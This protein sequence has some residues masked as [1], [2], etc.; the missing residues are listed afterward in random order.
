MQ[1]T[2]SVRTL[3]PAPIGAVYRAVWRWHFYA[4]LL[5]LPFLVL[6]A[7]TGGLYLFHK[8]ID[9]IVH[10]D[11][12][13]VP[14]A[15]GAGV[16][17]SVLVANAEKAVPGT[18]LTYITPADPGAAAA[19]GI[20]TP[21]GQR[22]L[23]YLDPSNGRV[24]GSIGEKSTVMGIVR[25][26]HSLAFF[27]VW[28][29]YVIEIVGGWTVVLVMTGLY[30]WWPRGG[31][32]GG[33][34]SVRGTPAKRVFW[35][36]LHAVSGL[37]AAF[38]LAFLAITGMPWSSFWGAQ[39]HRLVDEAGIGFPGG[40]WGDQPVST[41]PLGAV[42]PGVGWTMQDS[43]VPLS[44]GHHHGA[45]AVE[46]DAAALPPSIGLDEAVAIFDKAGLAPGYAVALPQ[47]PRGVY[48]GTVYPADLAKERAIHLDRYSG[49]TLIDVSFANYGWAGK[50]IEWGVNV[51]MGQEFGRL[52][53]IVLALACLL[54]IV[55]AAGALV[56]WWKRRPP[57]ALAAPP[58]PAERRP[59]IVVTAILL[60]L[61]L[62]Y[63]LTGLSMLAM[64][65]IDLFGGHML[66]ARAASAA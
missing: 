44:G 11:L 54:V 38:F 23:V 63:P 66:A 28:P 36:D 5:V 34:I 15:T 45:P 51:H 48:S 14:P 47:T 17:P 21:D 46:G 22:R 60:A 6:L 35:R 50:A 31:R 19:V 1:L 62:I 7:V 41:L 13:R 26:L 20:R 3:R 18:V 16:A 57:G 61:G 25:Q 9:A 58:W 10:A 56:M 27:G 4:G 64:L 8:E 24:K 55:M 37:L 12:L 65:A 29:P 30:L 40:A 49:K 59:V 39:T 53:Q 42:A 2:P 52:N 32:K 33:T 43:P